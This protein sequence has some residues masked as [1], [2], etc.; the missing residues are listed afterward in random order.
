MFRW[1]T[2]A[3]L[4]LCTGCLTAGAQ[5]SSIDVPAGSRVLL[6]AKGEGAQVYTCTDGHWVLKALDAKLFD[7]DGKQIGTHFAGPT[8][9]LD[10]GSEVKG[11]A[12]ASQSSPDAGSVAWLLIEAVPESGKGRFAAVTYIRR[13]NTHGGA[14]PKEACTGENLSVPYRADYTFY[15]AK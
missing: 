3:A 15:A 13:T 8:W 6:A 2:L 1:A 9:K 5:A 10:D 4:L 12:V 14:A 11:K 7:A